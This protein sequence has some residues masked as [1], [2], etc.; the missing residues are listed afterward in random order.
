MIRKHNSRNTKRFK[1]GAE[2]TQHVILMAKC[3]KCKKDN[4][5]PDKA[6]KYGQFKVQ[7]YACSCGTQ[8]REY[9]KDGKH[10]F[11]LKR[12]QGKGYVK[13]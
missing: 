6:W 3:P 1:H 7:A 13:A 11:T 9:T 5:K 12:Q 8:Y 2:K 4:T 10:S